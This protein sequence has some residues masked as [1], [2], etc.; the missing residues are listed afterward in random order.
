MVTQR[1]GWIVVAVAF[2]TVAA[3]RPIRAME[4]TF[5]VAGT[6][7]AVADGLTARL[8]LGDRGSAQYVVRWL[9][10]EDSN[11]LGKLVVEGRWD[12][13]GD[14][15]IFTFPNPGGTGRVVY[16]MSSCLPYRSF[17]KANCSPGL[18]VVASDLPGNRTWELWKTEFLVP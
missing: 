12:M 7:D 4:P 6:Y 8:T 15:L 2:V 17:G 10:E 11:V 9:A 5:G 1:V 18:H 13:Q 14:T 3:Y 16:Q